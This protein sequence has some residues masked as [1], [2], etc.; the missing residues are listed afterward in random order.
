[1]TNKKGRTRQQKEANKTNKQGTR[2]KTHFVSF[3]FL[4]SSRLK[5]RCK[6]THSNPGAVVFSLPLEFWKS[7]IL[8]TGKLF[9][10]SFSSVRYILKYDAAHHDTLSHLGMY[11]V[12]SYE[13]RMKQ[14]S[15]S[16]RSSENPTF[17]KFF[18]LSLQAL[19]SNTEAF[20]ASWDFA[21]RDVYI[22]W[23][24]RWSF[25]MCLTIPVRWA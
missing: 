20:W 3:R 12:M 6:L 18:K 4:S 16:V 8:V 15:F 2:H 22:F 7:W 19:K 1:M 5:L 24:E 9:F 21:E 17:V 10:E 13:D 14:E 11:R 25:K 23:S